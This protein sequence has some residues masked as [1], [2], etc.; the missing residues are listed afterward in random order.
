[1]ED[2]LNVPLHAS[3]FDV[4]R[5]CRR[6]L[7]SVSGVARVQFLPRRW[8]NFSMSIAYIIARIWEVKRVACYAVMRQLLHASVVA[9]PDHI[10]SYQ[11]SEECLCS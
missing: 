9:T 4:C 8:L 3:D 2:C 1:M 7:N 10:N 11:S 5:S 6:Q